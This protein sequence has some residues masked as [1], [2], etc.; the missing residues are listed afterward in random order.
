MS[1][2]VRAA[3]DTSRVGQS[4]W[5]WNAA[6]GRPHATAAVVLPERQAVPLPAGVA[7]EVGACLARR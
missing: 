7:A 6:W 5:V 2:L 1:V 4:V 3:S